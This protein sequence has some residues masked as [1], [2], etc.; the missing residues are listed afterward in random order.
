MAISSP[1]FWKLPLTYK[2]N[3]MV[4]SLKYPALQK[5]KQNEKQI[6]KQITLMGSICGFLWYKDSYHDRF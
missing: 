4:A 2:S 1:F 5:T 6:Q 3:S